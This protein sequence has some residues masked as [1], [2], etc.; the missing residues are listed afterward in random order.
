MKVF[1]FSK[2][3]NP[4]FGISKGFYLS[5][6]S[7]KA[8]MPPILMIVNPKGDGGAIEGFGAPLSAS[9]EKEDLGRPLQ[10]GAYV[11]T[12][13]DRK[14]VLKMLVLSKEEAGFDPDP[15]LESSL[16]VGIDPEL[17]TRMRATWTLA[18]LSFESHDPMVYPAVRF[19]L[20]LA[21]RLAELA[22]G[23][24]AD[25]VCQRYLMPYEIVQPI[26]ASA[27]IDVRDVVTIK[28]VQRQEGILVHT[29]GMQKF[30]LRELEL[31]CVGEVHTTAAAN[32][33]LSLCQS[34][35]E[36]RKIG[37]GD[38]VGAPDM[39]MQVAEGGLDR[40]LWEGIPC[41]ELLPPTQN[42]A[43]EALDAWTIAAEQAR[44]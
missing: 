29:L 8:V 7:T 32:F 41:F 11:V 15:F 24:V 31:A 35:L 4:G 39:P 30:A 6:L 26:Q 1:Q 10:R 28:L 22:D 44:R 42:T 37:V 34:T 23:V 17:A 36:G 38:R 19:L 2:P 5:V 18:Q 21:A 25:P 43:D 33:L 16:A 14:T 9:A 13:K 20:Q 12:T 27:K 3:K 40:R